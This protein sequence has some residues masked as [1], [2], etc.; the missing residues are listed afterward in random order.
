MLDLKFA[1]FGVL[2][3]VNIKSKKHTRNT[4]LLAS[5]SIPKF[6]RA[7]HKRLRISEPGH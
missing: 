5:S 7:C 6:T 4:H 2:R 3:R 1:S